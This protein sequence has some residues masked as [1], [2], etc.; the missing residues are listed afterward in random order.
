M[1]RGWVHE[2][3]IEP[4]KGDKSETGGIHV[5]AIPESAIEGEAV[6]EKEPYDFSG[7][8]CIRMIYL[9]AELIGK[10]VK[11]AIWTEDADG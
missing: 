8:G 9:P 1:I 6:V 3:D 5:A 2:Y 7:K 11:Y 4:V 10:R